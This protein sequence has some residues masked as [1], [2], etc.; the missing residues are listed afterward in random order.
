MRRAFCYWSN[1][2]ITLVKPSSG[3]VHVF[4]D[5]LD[6]EVLGFDGAQPALT[7]R[8][9]HRPGVLL[10]I[11]ILR[12]AQPRPIKSPAEARSADAILKS[13]G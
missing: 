1:S 10:K 13:Y 6:L 12:I 4:V 9:S 3:V 2:T 5:S 11:C 8:S 7:G